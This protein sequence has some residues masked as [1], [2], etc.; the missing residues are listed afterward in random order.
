MSMCQLSVSVVKE[1][2]Y[3]LLCL[4]AVRCE[5]VFPGLFSAT[6]RN[7]KAGDAQGSSVAKPPYKHFVVGLSLLPNILKHW[8]LIL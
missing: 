1:R 6:V 2:H 5:L 8:T 4:Q 7:H 3:L